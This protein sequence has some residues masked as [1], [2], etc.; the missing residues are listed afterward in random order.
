MNEY[1]FNI[2]MVGLDGQPMQISPSDSNHAMLG[3]MLAPLIAQSQSD[4]PVKSWGWAQ[5]LY[6]GKSLQL[7]K[8][9]VDK[10]KKTIRDLK[11]ATD[12]L[13]AQALEV[14]S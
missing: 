10:F 14:V 13:K 5:S 6:Q 7:D 8:S 1:N 9:D 12:M 4:D 11:Q 3:V 2:P